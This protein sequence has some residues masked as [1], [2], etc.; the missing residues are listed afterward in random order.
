MEIAN[1]LGLIDSNKFVI[2]VHFD[3]SNT[4]QISLLTKASKVFNKNIYAI[5]QA[6]YIIISDNKII[7]L[8]KT[9]LFQR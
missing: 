3:D 9:R 2:D 5:S 4:E 6:G 1:G 7:D 8:Y